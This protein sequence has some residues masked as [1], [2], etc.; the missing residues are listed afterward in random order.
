MF[1]IQNG[2]AVYDEMYRV[3]LYALTNNIQ[4][5]LL[6]PLP[7]PPFR[8]HWV[9]FTSTTHWG[10][11]RFLVWERTSASLLFAMLLTVCLSISLSLGYMIARAKTRIHHKQ[12]IKTNYGLLQVALNIIHWLICHSSRVEMSHLTSFFIFNSITWQYWAKNVLL[13]PGAHHAFS[14]YVKPS[15]YVYLMCLQSLHWCWCRPVCFPPV[16]TWAAATVSANLTAG[17]SLFS[18]LVMKRSMIQVNSCWM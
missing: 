3:C 5:L 15:W 17:W 1:P 12:K 13:K 18:V 6:L 16:G 2:L 11:R 4:L 7:P 14:V 10:C 8:K 9:M